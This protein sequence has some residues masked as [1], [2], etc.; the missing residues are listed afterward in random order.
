M[1]TTTQGQVAFD[2]L[3]QSYYTTKNGEVPLWDHPSLK[4]SKVLPKNYY[5]FTNVESTVEHFRRGLLDERDF[6]IL[7]VLGDAVCAN[8]GQLRRYLGSKYSPSQTSNRL[9]RLRKHGFVDRWKVRIRGQE[10]EIKP[11]APFTLGMAGYKLMKHYYNSEFFMDS[12]RWDTLGIGGIKRYVS[13]NELRCIMV[14]MSILKKWTWNPVIGGHNKNHRP[15]AVGLID[16]PNGMVNFLI[17]RVQTSQNF[18]GFF[19]ERLYNWSTLYEKYGHIKIADF[20]DYETY[21]IIFAPTL[22]VAEQ[23]QKELM[24]ETYPFS[25][26]ICVEEDLLTSGFN[27]AFYVPTSEKLKRIRLGF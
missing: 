1:E 3:E 17:D 19:K 11:P 20:P 4:G 5:P 18:I 14:E 7:K 25:I 8:E 10:E 2:N 24:L 12:N 13:M 27:T 16:S 23:L 26:W 22:S 6:T 15:L 9:D 21:S